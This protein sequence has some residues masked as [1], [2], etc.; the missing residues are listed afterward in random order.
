MAITLNANLFLG[1]LSNLICYLDVADVLKLDSLKLNK[2]CK[3][4]DVKYGDSILFRS[5]DIPSVT[6]MPTTSTLLTAVLPTTKEQ[7]LSVSKYKTVQLTINEWLMR[8]AFDGEYAMSDYVAYLMKTMRASKEKYIF[9]ELVGLLDGYTPTNAEQTIT[10]NMFDITSLLDP[11]QL[12]MAETYN[13]NTFIKALIK[14][15]IKLETPYNKFNDDTFTEIV[16]NEDM[17]LFSTD[18]LEANILVDTFAKLFNSDKISKEFKYGDS[19][20]IPQDLFTTLTNTFLC[21]LAHREKF[22]YGYAFSVATSF[23]DAS[24]LNT[25]NWLHFAYYIGS[26]NAYPCIKFIAAY[27]LTPTAL[28]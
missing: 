11:A 12:Q 1:A 7:V 22:Q 19:V 9:D 10:I 23:F 24:T 6:N 3:K 8:G 4:R 16:S 25:N 28:S 26:V 14:A 27:T 21:Y 20:T 2:V 13:T 5:A 18:N 17:V 15:Q